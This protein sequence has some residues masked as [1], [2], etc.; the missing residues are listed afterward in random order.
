MPTLLEKGQ[1]RR[2]D[3]SWVEAGAEV[4]STG[5]V[6]ISLPHWQALTDD[7]RTSSLRRIGVW[8]EVDVE[9]DA[10]PQLDCLPLIAIRFPAFNDGRG[11]SLATLLRTRFRF[12]GQLRAAGA[13]HEDIVHYL[14]RCGF[15]SVLLPDG[16]NVAVALRGF[17]LMSDYYQASAIESR[18]AFRR[19]AR[20]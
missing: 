18:P 10:V 3:W 6:I 2:D 4:P 5:D 1:I 20:G 8:L 11:L 19:V 12:E 15:D 13:V 9:P 14:V 7:Q 17:A 16:R